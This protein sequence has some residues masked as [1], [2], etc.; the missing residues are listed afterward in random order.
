MSVSV[1]IR[2]EVPSQI[3]SVSAV[4]GEI[5]HTMTTKTARELRDL[6]EK[7][8]EGWSNT[9]N[10]SSGFDEVRWNTTFNFGQTVSSVKVFTYSKKYAIVNE[11]SPRHPI[12]PRRARMLKFRT[13]YRAATRPKVIGSRAPSRFGEF[14]STPIVPDHPGFEARKFDEAIADE[15][16]PTFEKDIQDAI[17]AA[18]EANS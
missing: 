9:M 13:G 12:V 4:M 8:T 11:G 18:V 1:K 15:Y 6:F 7:T 10:P 16:A 3:L 2:V 14:A 5:R 17:D